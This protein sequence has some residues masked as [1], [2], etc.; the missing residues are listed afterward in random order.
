VEDLTDSL[1][2]AADVVAVR[3]AVCRNQQRVGAIDPE[4]I[5]KWRSVLRVS[6]A[7]RHEV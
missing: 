5:Q 4:A 6:A 3:S 1:L 7:D 2:A